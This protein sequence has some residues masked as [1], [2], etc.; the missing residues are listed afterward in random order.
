VGQETA[1]IGIAFSE[2]PSKVEFLLL[3]PPKGLPA[4]ISGELG[5]ERELY[6]FVHEHIGVLDV[7]RDNPFARLVLR[8][9]IERKIPHMTQKTS[10]PKHLIGALL[11]HEVEV[12]FGEALLEAS[13][14]LEIG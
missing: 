4:I 5:A 12:E 6:D 7:G 8:S 2:P 10:A 14:F 1:I 11:G 13:F 9:H 3:L